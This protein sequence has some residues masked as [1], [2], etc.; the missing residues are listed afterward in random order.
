M[1][2]KK[3]HRLVQFL[4]LEDGTR[5]SGTAVIMIISWGTSISN[6][7]LKQ[8]DP[9]CH[10]KWLKRW[11]KPKGKSDLATLKIISRLIFPPFYYGQLNYQTC[12]R[13]S[14][15]IRIKSFF[16]PEKRE[17]SYFFPIFV[18]HCTRA[19][20][21]RSVTWRPVKTLQSVNRVYFSLCFKSSIAWTKRTEMD[22]KGV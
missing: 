8:A 2:K 9:P 22:G 12:F 11:G 13:D 10:E 20:R 14:H 19:D 16:F 21:H 1:D 17:P 5:E 3:R 7:C 4:H 18:E 15:L 6:Q